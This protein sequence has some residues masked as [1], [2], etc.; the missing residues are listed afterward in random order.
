M[1][2]VLA[3]VQLCSLKVTKDSLQF[4]V[5]EISGLAGVVTATGNLPETPSG[6]AARYEH[7]AGG[8]HKNKT[9]FYF[10]Q[11][12]KWSCHGPF[13]FGTSVVLDNLTT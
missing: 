9:N 6:R 4:V 5:Q 2:E 12:S 1:F 10:V 7:H 13:F 11:L 3:E 8:R